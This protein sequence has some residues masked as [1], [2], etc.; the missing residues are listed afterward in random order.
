MSKKIFF[1]TLTIFSIVNTANAMRQ[2]AFPTGS[3]QPF[4]PVATQPGTWDD[5][6][7]I[8]G[9][10][11]FVEYGPQIVIE[12]PE[13]AFSQDRGY[14]MEFATAHAFNMHRELT[15]F[16]GLNLDKITDIVLAIN[17]C[18]GNPRTYFDSVFV[19]GRPLLYYAIPSREAYDYLVNT[20]GMNDWIL[21]RSEGSTV[22]AMYKKR[23]AKRTRVVSRQLSQYSPQ[24]DESNE[25]MDVDEDY[26]YEEMHNVN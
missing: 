17:E 22:N 18:G 24:G 16:G 1:V 11:T 26:S 12:S 6:A 9:E 21:V 15:C 4:T 8:M 23:W 14:P 19:N 20:V 5:L 3:R 25:E 10:P 13:A 2:V 7:S